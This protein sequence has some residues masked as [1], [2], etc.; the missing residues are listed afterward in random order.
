MLPI[1]APYMVQKRK[2]QSK[3]FKR[4][5]LPIE[6]IF[7]Y[8][9]LLCLAIAS[10]YWYVHKSQQYE[11]GFDKTYHVLQF[12]LHYQSIIQQHQFDLLLKQYEEQYVHLSIMFHQQIIAIINF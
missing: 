12:G 1:E 4:Q 9:I 6:I 8:G 7:I 3:N 2:I 10:V 5:I 11:R